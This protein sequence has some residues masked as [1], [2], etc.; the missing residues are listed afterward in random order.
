IQ[1]GKY[2][3]YIPQLDEL[4]G[5]KMRIE[6]GHALAPSEPGIGID[7]DWDAVKARSIAEFT[8]AIVK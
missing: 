8:T 3:E 7:W 1:N 4:T 6:D 5:A 2:V